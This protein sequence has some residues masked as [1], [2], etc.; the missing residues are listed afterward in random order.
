MPRSPRSRYDRCMRK[1]L[2][3]L[4]CAGAL[5]TDIAALPAQADQTDPQLN[6]LFQQLYEA[7]NAATA[8]R[9]EN[10]ILRILSQSGSATAD[11]L[12]QRG[13]EAMNRG[14]FELSLTTLNSLIKLQPNFAE[15]WNRRATLYFLTGRL[16][17]SIADCEKA[18][19]LEP[20]HFGAWAGLGQIYIILNRRNDAMRAF[21]RALAANPHLAG[22]RRY[23]DAVR[24]MD[25]GR[26]I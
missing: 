20:R 7:P 19:S 16:D 24:R 26:E 21:Q 23:L 15:A 4:M 13:T 10:N 12:L 2:L 25:G 5:A 18:L 17:A 9:F 22:A 8:T 6:F 11:L 1:V 3:G 14:E